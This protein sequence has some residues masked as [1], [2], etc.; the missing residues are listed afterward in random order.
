MRCD[1]AGVCPSG[2]ESLTRP[3]EGTNQRGLLAM[4][5]VAALLMAAAIVAYLKHASRGRGCRRVL[6][7]VWP[8]V[9]LPRYLWLGALSWFA[10]SLCSAVHWAAYAQNGLG[11]PWLLILSY[12]MEMISYLLLLRIV[13]S[14]GCGFGISAACTTAPEDGRPRPVDVAFLCTVLFFAGMCLVLVTSE[15]FAERPHAF[16]SDVGVIFAFFFLAILAWYLGHLPG[17]RDA[18]PDA[19]KRGYYN[20]LL[21]VGGAWLAHL[22]LF[23]FVSNTLPPYRAQVVRWRCVRA[24]LAV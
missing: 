24:H 17:V 23:V 1:L 22:P 3:Q 8:A 14:V 2:R 19:A 11:L 6:P 20:R 13:L 16:D 4:Y 9:M 21:V 15:G 10:M 5:S 7:L 12:I 18:E